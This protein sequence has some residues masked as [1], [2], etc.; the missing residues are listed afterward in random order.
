MFFIGVLHGLPD[1][2]LTEA[3][4]IINQLAI[5]LVQLAGS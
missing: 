2:F 1:V 5:V 3:S 4:F